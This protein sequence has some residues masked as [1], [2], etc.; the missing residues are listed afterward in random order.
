M[1]DFF[2]VILQV[3]TNEV[4]T[5]PNIILF[6]SKIIRIMVGQIKNEQSQKLLFRDCPFVFYYF[7]QF[8]QTYNQI[9]FLYSLHDLY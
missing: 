7:I 1:S 6:L 8:I 2:M 3:F 9:L 4:N 5:F